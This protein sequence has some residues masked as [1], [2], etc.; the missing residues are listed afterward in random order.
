MFNSILESR[1]IW[2]DD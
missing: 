1:T 2:N